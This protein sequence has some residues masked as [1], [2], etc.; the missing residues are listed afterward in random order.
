VQNKNNYFFKHHDDHMIDSKLGLLPVLANI[1]KL[2]Q[3]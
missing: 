3:I 1:R 2:K